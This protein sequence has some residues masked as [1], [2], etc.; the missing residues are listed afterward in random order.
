MDFERASI[1]AYLGTFPESSVA[2]R[3]FHLGQALYR[4]AQEIGL[5]E[6][7][8]A[9]DDFRLRVKTIA[10]LAFLPIDEVVEGYELV[11]VGFEEDE[12]EFLAYFE[13]TYTGR[14]TPNGR[15]RPLFERHLWN[16]DH[17]MTSGSLRTNNAIESSHCAFARGVAQSDRPSVYRFIESLH[18]QQ[19][20]TCGAINIASRKPN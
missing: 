9:S 18:V 15:R 5:S 14:S 1:D 19:N 17:R 10:A 4:K 20:I 6:K 2:G 13:S 11:A 12:K 8:K 3:I 16:V 7:Y